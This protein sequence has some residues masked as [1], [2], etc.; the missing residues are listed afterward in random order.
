LILESSLLDLTA[1]LKNLEKEEDSGGESAGLEHR[2][3]RNDPLPFDVLKEVDVDFSLNAK[4]IRARDANFE[5]GSLILTLEDGKLNVDTLEAT[6][7][8]TRISGNLHLYSESPPRVAAKFLVQDFDLGGLLQELRVSEEVRSHLDIAVDFNSKGASVHDLMAGLNGSVGAVMG[9]G[10]LTHYL[11]LLS[12]GLTRKVIHF[13][14]SHHKGGEIKCAVV[15]F[16]ISSGIATS[17][18]FV[19]DTEAGVL[20]GEGDI[21]LNTE[22]VNFLLVP[23]P[24]FPSLMDFW[25]KLRV[26]GTIMDPKVRPDMLSVLTKGATALSALV[27]GPLGLLAPFVNLGAYKSHPCKVE[28]IGK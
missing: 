12:L 16:D 7:K 3:F 6:Y 25:T 2:L 27:V 5:F 24:R 11:D 20:T 14:G 19:F 8:Q 21:N 15:Q 17:R 26:S 28:S 9:K 4:N 18:A 22:Q 23:Q 13:W 10:Y 1:L